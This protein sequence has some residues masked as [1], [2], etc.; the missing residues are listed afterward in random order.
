MAALLVGLAALAAVRWSGRWTLLVSAGVLVVGLVVVLAA[1]RVVR[2]D[3]ASSQGANRATSGRYHLIQRGLELF[4]DRPVWGYGSASFVKE[5]QTRKRSSNQ[6]AASASHTI[7]VTVAAEQGLVGLA[8]Y[9]ALLVAAFARL[10]AGARSPPR[11]AIAAAFT[12][13]VF[14]TLL[15][16]DFLEDPVT[17]TLL[18][19]G[20]VLAWQQGRRPCAAGEPAPART[21]VAA[22]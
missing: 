13:L 5:Y 8:L 15:Y 1:P 11:V 3:V 20:T 10:Y 18:G 12:A 22:A 21:P 16:A 7:P 9:L 19:I 4:A 17:W 6:G 2:F 14:H